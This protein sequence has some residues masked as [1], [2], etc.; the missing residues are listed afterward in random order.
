MQDKPHISISYCDKLFATLSFLYT[1]T[2]TF[3]FN[4]DTISRTTNSH[5]LS[6]FTF[7]TPFTSIK[8]FTS[9]AVRLFSR[10]RH[11]SSNVHD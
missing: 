7:C 8:V 3:D 10:R 4:L 2:F 9:H 1:Q 11:S 5:F 6:I